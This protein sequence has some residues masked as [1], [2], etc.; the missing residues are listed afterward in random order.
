[1]NNGH[2]FEVNNYWDQNIM[3]CVPFFCCFSTLFFAVDF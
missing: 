1:M 2:L 3:P